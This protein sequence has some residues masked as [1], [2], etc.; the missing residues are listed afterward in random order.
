ET[1]EQARGLGLALTLLHQHMGQL[2]QDTRESILTNARTRVVFQC[3]PEDAR[4]FAREFAPLDAGSLMNLPRFNAAVRMAANGQ[5]SSPFTIRTLQA[6][7][8]TEPGI[9]EEI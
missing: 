9:G 8:P 5:T 7:A 4:T 2:P 6:P 3:G 1:L